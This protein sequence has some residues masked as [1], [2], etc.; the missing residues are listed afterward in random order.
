MVSKVFLFNEDHWLYCS[1]VELVDGVY[2]GD[3]V[4]GAWYLAH[5]TKTNTS[6]AYRTSGERRNGRNPVNTLTS[7]LIWMCYPYKSRFDYNS[8]I[9]DAK[10]RY[11]AGEEANYS[12]EPT[13][14]EIEEEYDDEIPF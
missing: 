5:D 12:L 6:K 1:D 7:N 3:V 9:E 13:A 11:K 10:E 14:R 8:V 2:T 4:N